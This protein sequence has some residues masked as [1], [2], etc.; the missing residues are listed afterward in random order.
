MQLTELGVNHEETNRF[1][2]GAHARLGRLRQSG[3]GRCAR[4]RRR[5]DGFDQKNDV[6]TPNELFF[7]R[8]ADAARR[9]GRERRPQPLLQLEPERHPHL[10]R[11]YGLDGHDVVRLQYE[12]RR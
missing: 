8:P 3:P 12:D 4:G 9:V 10:E 7:E 1:T 2:G 5:V 11:P 6:W